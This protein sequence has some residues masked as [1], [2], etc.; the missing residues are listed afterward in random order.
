LPSAQSQAYNS[1]IKPLL[2]GHLRST[3]KLLP[4]VAFWLVPQL[5]ERKKLQ[6]LIVELAERFSAPVFVPHVTVYSCWRSDQQRE[7]AVIAGLADNCQPITMALLGLAEKDRLTQTLFC[8]LQKSTALTRLSHSLGE[9]I[10]RSAGH[11]LEP[12]LSLLY[13]NLPASV[14]ETLVHETMI[15]LQEIRCDELWAVAIPGQLN[16]P[17]D[18][19]GWQTLLIRRLDSL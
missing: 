5:E 15:P 12:H 19:R 3:S 18:F 16:A 1:K 2:E 6:S 11:D 13:Q 17:D 8:E 4:R 7:L 14:R 9:G 10:S